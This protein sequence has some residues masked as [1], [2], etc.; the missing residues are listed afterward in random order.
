MDGAS[1]WSGFENT[2]KDKVKKKS[3]Y[4][5]NFI[6]DYKVYKLGMSVANRSIIRIS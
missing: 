6:T 3:V 2:S 1:G 4:L 5:L